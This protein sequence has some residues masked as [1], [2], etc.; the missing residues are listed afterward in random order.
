MLTI[1]HM[2][3]KTDQLPNPQEVVRFYHEERGS[4]ENDPVHAAEILAP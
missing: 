2:P 1:A 4:P 3:S